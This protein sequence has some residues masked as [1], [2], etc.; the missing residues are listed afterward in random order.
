MT[1]RERFL[2]VM[3]GLLMLMGG[4]VYGARAVM[5]N[6]N[7]K[8]AQLAVLEGEVREKQRTVRLSHLAADRMRLYER[9]ALPADV[10]KARSLYQ[11]WLLRSV[12]DVGFDEPNVTVVSSTS[13]RDLYHQLGFTLSGRGDL[14]QLVEFLHAFYAADYLHRIRRLHIKPVSGTKKLE[15]AMSI[16][17]LSLPTALHVD[18]LSEFE[19]GRLAFGDLDNYLQTILYRNF[20]GPP[21]RPPQLDTLADRT[22]TTNSTLSFTV[23]AKDPDPLDRLRFSMEGD[24]PEARFDP[25]SGEFR[26]QPQSPGQ[27]EVAFSVT[28]DGWPPKSHSRQMRITVTNPPPAAPPPPAVV[29]KPSFEQAQFAFV[30]AITESGGRRQAWINVRTEARL[31]KLH[32]GDEFQI[33]EV[34]VTIVQINDRSV[35]MEAAVLEKQF[36]VALG[37]SLAQGSG[38]APQSNGLAAPAS[39]SAAPAGSAAASGSAPASGSAAATRPPAALGRPAPPSSG[40]AQSG[41]S[42]A[43]TGGRPA[44][45]SGRTFQRGG[46]R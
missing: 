44:P 24:L 19:S 1:K 15:V 25:R 32:E 36:D 26:W 10:Q 17:S 37:Q 8:R 27:Y 4:F 46:R 30:T 16:E 43:P 40:S 33:G 28:D 5:Q 42:S 7:A 11:T 29:R 31:L 45:T 34:P 14:K 3:V 18:T 20:T 22:A 9:R 35:E 38:T 2:G 13:T 21:N 41:G 23:T 39:G 12:T 6:I